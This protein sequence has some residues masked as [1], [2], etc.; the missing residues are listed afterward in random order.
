MIK[1][2][3][4][5][6]LIAFFALMTLATSV[7]AYYYG[8]YGRVYGYAYSAGGYPVYNMHPHAYGPRGWGHYGPYYHGGYLYPHHGYYNSYHQ[9]YP[10]HYWRGYTPWYHN[11]WPYQYRV[12]QRWYP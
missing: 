10:N 7:S 6:V 4:S 8:P 3:I 5:L 2:I 11:Y 9:W 1:K 12:Y